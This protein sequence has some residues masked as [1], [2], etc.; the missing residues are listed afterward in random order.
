MK[1]ESRP[2]QRI[3]IQMD[4][5]MSWKVISPFGSMLWSILDGLTEAVQVYSPY[6]FH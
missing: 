6:M 3:F 2:E 5:I 4:D 1:I